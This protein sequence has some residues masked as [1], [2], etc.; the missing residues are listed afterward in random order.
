[1]LKAILSYS[2]KVPA[3]SEYSS[4]GYSLSLETEL[5][6]GLGQAKIQERIHQTFELV[7]AAVEQELASGKP[8]S[9]PVSDVSEN[10]QDAMKGSVDR[11]SNRQI[12]FATDLAS[13]QGIAISELNARVQELY[14]VD[15]IYDLTK[16]DAS[17]LLDSLKTGGHKK[18]A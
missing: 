14:K 3:E 11:A 1:M 17:K 10:H 12:R 13:Q 16:K 18:A 2:K 15:N 4:Q 9:V 5:P 7:K 8:K 6:E